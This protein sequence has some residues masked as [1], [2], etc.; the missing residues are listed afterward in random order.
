MRRRYLVRWRSIGS[1]A[2]NLPTDTALGEQGNAHNQQLYTGNATTTECL[3]KRKRHSGPPPSQS[4]AG[5]A[6]PTANGSSIAQA[7]TLYSNGEG[8]SITMQ[9]A[10]ALFRSPANS[11]KKYTRPP[12]SKLYTSLELD[13]EKFLQL[14]AAAKTYM[15]DPDH[16]DRREC[17]GQRGKG[18]SEVVK[19]KLWNTVARFLDEEGHGHSHFG[20]QVLGE[21]GLK[22][23]M[24][25][26]L[27]K[28]RIIGTVMPLL[29]RM[30]TNERQ[31]QY[32]VVTRKGG[33]SST[34]RSLE[35][36][37]TERASSGNPEHLVQDDSVKLAGGT[38]ISDASQPGATLHYYDTVQLRFNVIRNNQRVSPPYDL[39][40]KE[41][42]DLQTVFLKALPYL[43]GRS[44]DDLQIRVLMPSGLTLIQD[45][46]DWIKALNKINQV[47]WMDNEMKVLLEA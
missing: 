23:S 17:V 30:V 36:S 16:P 37:R 11:S 35:N 9:S 8:T 13:P 19:M 28:S 26:P 40:A 15:L 38:Q 10:A 25:W 14:Q 18:D 4:K 43:S 5:S 39:T 20:S 22:R 2:E 12:M 42:P 32:A 7:S 41:C 31:R 33:S 46:D 21:Q 6:Y 29:R 3:R 45:D 1:P 24:V 47:E 27:D 44:H 34:P